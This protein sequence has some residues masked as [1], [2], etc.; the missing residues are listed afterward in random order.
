M[1]RS[2]LANRSKVSHGAGQWCGRK[3]DVLDSPGLRPTPDRVRE[4]LFNWI[5]QEVVVARCLDLFAGSGALGFEALSRGAKEVV[6][7]ESNPALVD[8][9]NYSAE[10][11]GSE[12]HVI[13][14]ADAMSWLQQQ[15][16][17]FDIIF[18]KDPPFGQNLIEPCCDLIKEQSLLNNRGLVYIE[19]EKELSLPAGWK[20]IK[21][22]TA[23][24]VQTMLI[25]LDN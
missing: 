24:N 1:A 10:V 23:G 8:R 11:L 13:H 12:Q 3:L 19:S 6:L 17:A 16:S 18:L 20:M 7:V 2:A 5:Q 22:S 25:E 9:L 14:H 21:Q 4:T 15:T